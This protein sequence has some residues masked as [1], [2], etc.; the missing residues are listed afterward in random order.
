MSRSTV[1]TCLP[2]GM[3][4]RGPSVIIG[5][6]DWLGITAGGL[7]GLAFSLALWWMQYR[8][9]VPRLAFNDSVSRLTSAHGTVYRVKFENR[10]RR[11]AVIDVSLD[12]R[13]FFGQ[14]V[15]AYNEA[16][17][18]HTSQSVGIP[19]PGKVMRLAPG[20]SRIVR[21]DLRPTMWDHVNPRLVAAIGVDRTDERETQLER[22]LTATPEAY[23]RVRVLGYDEI[24]GSRKYFESGKYRV[25]HIV[26]G[27]FSGNTARAQPRK[28]SNGF[29]SSAD[30]HDASAA[31]EPTSLASPRM[32]MHSCPGVG[33][34]AALAGVIVTGVLVRSRARR[35]GLRRQ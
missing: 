31:V 7:V 19:T 15:V 4:S 10:S 29:E 30:D 23:M 12:V 3:C 1:L 18:R 14:S 16:T 9:L 32:Q 2:G 21:L 27:P 22:L 24:S 6:M 11:R 13:V 34:V 28:P 25:Q 35:D 20:V 17:L 26:T 8:V 33:L 5:R